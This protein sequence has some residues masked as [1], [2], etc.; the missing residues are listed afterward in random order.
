MLGRVNAAMRL[1]SLGMLPIGALAGGFIASKIGI[2][3]TFWIGGTGALLSTL[4]LV[5]VLSSN[6]PAEE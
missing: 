4:W 1:A 3:N 2:T 6:I 5:P